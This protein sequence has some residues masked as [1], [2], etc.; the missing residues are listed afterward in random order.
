MS[1]KLITLVIVSGGV[2][3]SAFPAV[4]SNLENIIHSSADTASL[5]NRGQTPGVTD[6]SV[7]QANID[8]TICVPG[9]AKS[10]RPAYAF[11]GPLKR[12]LMRARHP[13]ES[14]RL[15]E[16]DHLIPLSIG[17]APSDPHNLW[18]EPWTGQNNAADK[19]ALEFVLWRLVCRH[20]V[21]LATAQGAIASNWIAAYQRYAT[22]ENLTRF[23]FS[24]GDGQ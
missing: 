5:P 4:R 9:Y 8:Q 2:A 3:L 7:S 18:L 13:G 14:F 12:R 24:H 17:G 10:V 6:V 11:T 15:Y 23:H 1:M 21:P 22:P 16:L 19:D 20:E